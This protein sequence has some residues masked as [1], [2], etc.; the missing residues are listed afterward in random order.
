M[1]ACYTGDCYT[2]TVPGVPVSNPVKVDM[3]LCT[4]W[5]ES[6]V[7]LSHSSCLSVRSGSG[8]DRRTCPFV[9][10][11][12]GT[13]PR[14]FRPCDR[15]QELIDGFVGTCQGHYSKAPANVYQPGRKLI[16]CLSIT[17]TWL[18]AEASLPARLSLDIQFLIEKSVVTVLLVL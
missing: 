6:T 1:P 16:M 17:H 13:Y 18:R 15:L 2:G 5:H 14:F 9:R 3:F 8:T 11:P 10:S 7:L 4:G 12:P